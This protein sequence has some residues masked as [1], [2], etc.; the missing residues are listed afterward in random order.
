MN[1]P[2]D[3]LSRVFRNEVLRYRNAVVLMFIA[4]SLPVVFLGVIWPQNYKAASLILVDQKKIIQPL[5]EGV[6][7]PTEVTD[8]A[9]IAREL[10]NGHK[11]MNTILE[12]EGW[13]KDKPSPAEQ[14]R[15]IEKLKK[16]T[17]ISSMGSNLIK[18]EY[19]D[20]EAVRAADTANYLA[21]LLLAESTEKKSQESGTAF[22]FLDKQV[23]EYHKKLLEAEN[24]LKE[25]R[26]KNIDA[27]PGTEAEVAARISEIHRSLEQ[28]QLELAEVLSKK[29]SLESQLAGEAGI[30]VSLTR[31]AQYQAQLAEMQAE[32]DRLRLS[33]H[34]THPN[35]IRVKH[36]MRDLAEAIDEKQNRGASVATHDNKQPFS[37]KGVFINPLYEELR[38]E[39]S[40]TKTTIDT[41]RVRIAQT[42]QRLKHELERGRRIHVSELILAELTRDYEVN[43]DIYRQLLKRRENARVSMSLDQEEQGLNLRIQERAIVPVRPSGLRFLHFAA[44]SLVLGILVPVGLICLKVMYDPRVCFKSTISEKLSLPVLAVI[45]HLSTLREAR[46]KAWDGRLLGLLVL[47]YLGIFTYVGWLKFTGGLTIEAGDALRFIGIY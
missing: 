30:T 6:A 25:F 28:T 18:I 17:Y 12:K 13:L 46:W 44:I 37:D 31:E 1:I 32:L 41:L 39:L 3:E 34:D 29:G 42:E 35:V 2:F 26:S 40:A 5:T 8:F 4:I 21:E 36:Q 14:E 27:Q 33:Y 7:V 16:R 22:E 20:E 47:L 9:Q 11:I 38:R 15:I 24:K 23:S 45:P 19:K 10:I 43:R